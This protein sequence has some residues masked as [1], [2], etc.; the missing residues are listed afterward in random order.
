MK[1]ESLETHAVQKEK[2]GGGKKKKKHTKTQ[3]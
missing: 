3:K 1:K 2:E